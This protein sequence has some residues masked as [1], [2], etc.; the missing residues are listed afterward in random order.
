V[1]L[2]PEEFDERLV[3]V[4]REL[5]AEI[6]SLKSAGNRQCQKWLDTEAAKLNPKLSA[7]EKNRKI[8][9]EG[10]ERIC[11]ARGSILATATRNC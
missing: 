2:D 11:D 5:K 8:L 6:A 4:V 7:D 9:R 1:D 10:Y 3:A